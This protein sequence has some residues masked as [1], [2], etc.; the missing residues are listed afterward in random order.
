[1]ELDDIWMVFHL[2]EEI[3]LTGNITQVFILSKNDQKLWNSD[4]DRDV[5]F[6]ENDIFKT[7]LLIERRPLLYTLYLSR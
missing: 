7:T 2:L 3:H 6:V 1:M 5:S 4:S